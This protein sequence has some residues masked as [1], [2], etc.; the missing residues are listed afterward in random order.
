M[1]LAKRTYII[2]LTIVVSC[3]VSVALLSGCGGGSPQQP[4]AGLTITTASLP[5]GTSDT[6]YS[7]TIQASGGVAPFAWTVSAGALPHNVALSN[8]TTNTVTISGTPDTAAQGVGFSVKVT[9]SA[10]QSASQSYTVSILLEP[11]TLTLSPASLSFTQLVA[12]PSSAQAE[13]VTNTGTAAVAISSIA[14]IGNPAEFGQNNTCGSSLAAGLSCTVNVTFTP[15]QLGPMGA[16]LSIIDN[17]VGSPHNVS[18][19]GV[20]LT[21]GSNATLSATRLTFGGSQLV[22][23]TSGALSVKLANYGTTALNITSITATTNF[24]ESDNCQGSNL[25]SGANCTIKVTFTPTAAGDVTGTISVTDDASGNPQTVTLSGAGTTTS[26]TLTGNCFYA[27]DPAGLQCAETQEPTLCPPGQPANTTSVS[28]CGGGGPTR[29]DDSR[30][31]S[32]GTG[33]RCVAQ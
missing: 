10:S 2:R 13:V 33:G 16:A 28:S 26:Y 32:G 22:G 14:L 11:D 7:Q 12:T 17:T 4:V 29:V 30:R 9:D 27:V 18:L 31:C 15:S 19:T 1:K 25:A 24:G 21:S 5:N 3:V 8:S 23:T 20:G 6:P